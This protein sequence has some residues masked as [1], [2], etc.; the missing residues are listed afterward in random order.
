MVSSYLVEQ[1]DPAQTRHLDVRDDQVVEPLLGQLARLLH[2][3]VHGRH[4]HVLQQLHVLGV[5]DFRV[6]RDRLQ[7]LVAGHHD[8]H[9][10]AARAGLDD[11]IAER[12]LHFRHLLLHHL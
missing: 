1:F 10:A 7:H 5:D 8:R 11:L 9:G 4:D 2:G 12:F 3:L 6:D